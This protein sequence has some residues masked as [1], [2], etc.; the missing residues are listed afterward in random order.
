MKNQ[1]LGFFCLLFST[2]ILA[3]ETPQPNYRQAARFSP[4]NIAKMV[5]STSVNPNWL[6]NGN[7]FWYQYKTASEGSKYFLVDADKKTK[8]PQTRSQPSP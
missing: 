3:Q 6:Q 1:L 5:H 2:I 7:R 4:E 8:T